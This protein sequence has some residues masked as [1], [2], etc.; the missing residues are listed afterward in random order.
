MGDNIL[1]LTTAIDLKGMEKGFNAIKKGTMSTAKAVNKILDTIS[2]TIKK[3][4]S[5]YFLKN[6]FDKLKEYLDSSIRKNSEF[7]ASMKNLR[8]SMAAAFQPIYEAIAPALTYLVQI[9]NYVVQAVGRFIAAISGKSY[10]Q[11]LKNAEA[12]SK[13]KDALDGVGGAAKEAQRQ[14]MGFDEIN[15]LNEETGS[16]SGTGMSF[17]E[18]DLGSAAGAIDDFA[19]K[20][21]EL[22]LS[23]QFEEAGNLVAEAANKIIAALD[24][25]KIASRTAGWINNLTDFVNAVGYGI[26]WG[27]L[28][29]K[30]A[31]GVNSLLSKINGKQIGR[32]LALKFVIGIGFLAD[33]LKDIDGKTAGKTLGDA[34]LGFAQGL[35]STISESLDSEF[36]EKLNTNITE[37]FAAFT[38]KFMESMRIAV[39]TIIKE[40]PEVLRTIG[41]IGESLLTALSDALSVMDEEVVIGKLDAFDRNG[42]QLNKVGTRWEALGISIAEGFQKIDWKNL[43]TTGAKG[44]G[45]LA[46]GIADMLTSAVN[47]VKWGDIGKAIIEGIASIDW[48]GLL[49]SAGNLI[50]AIGNGLIEL[51]LG[52]IDAVLGTDMAGTYRAWVEDTASRIANDLRSTEETVR[53]PDQDGQQVQGVAS[54]DFQRIVASGEAAVKTAEDGARYIEGAGGIIYKEL[55][56]TNEKVMEAIKL[57]EECDFDAFNE[58]INELAES[59]VSIDDFLAGLDS[60]YGAYVGEGQSG[61]DHANAKIILEEVGTSFGEITESADGAAESVSGLES[62]VTE[63]TSAAG[64]EIS[65]FSQG[66]V[67]D[68]N[69]VGNAALNAGSALGWL[70]SIQLGPIGSSISNGY[71]PNYK[72]YFEGL[73]Y[74][75]EGAV[76]PPNREFLAVFGDQRSGNNIETPEALLRQVVREESGS[77]GGGRVEELLSELLAAVAGIRIGDDV[78]GR[79]AARYNRKHGRAV[80]G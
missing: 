69:A 16:G 20:L 22:I 3:L 73:Y 2:G 31:K 58:K 77:A 49:E 28:G 26:N 12:L 21:R 10:S 66:A 50:I 33:F 39:D 42:F 23:G 13:Q 41:T 35:G 30:F 60:F 44:S 25:E 29:S 17:N 53:L 80:G 74:G 6:V 32:L 9:L 54:G 64:S 78:I 46:I 61:R 24:L 79:S 71:N 1:K 59:G 55:T 75:A 65:S 15:K 19:K 51:I 57:W 27:E 5:V 43:L 52:C 18:L 38:P 48:S 67:S 11:M 14:L 34:M 7:A 56:D 76:I 68:L 37:G 40:A 72:P 45:D 8:G 36:W 63:T 47:S 62:Q 4:V 70:G